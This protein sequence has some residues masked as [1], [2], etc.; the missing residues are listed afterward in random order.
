MKLDILYED[1]HIIVAYKPSGILS[2][3]DIS[4]DPDMLTLIKEYLVEKYNKPGEAYLGLVHRLDRNTS[5]VMVFAKTS[6]AASRLSEQIRNEGFNKE[7]LAI[8][9]GSLKPNNEFITLKHNLEKNEKENKSYVS[10]KGNAKEAVLMYQVLDSKNNLSLVKIKLITGRHHQIRTQFSHIGH[11]V[12]G[13]VKYGS[14]NKCGNY[15]SL[16]AYKLNIIHPTL[17]EPLEFK[18]LEQ[19]KIFDIFGSNIIE[20]YNI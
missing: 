10:N 4:K 3:E 11:P 19:D 5:G 6:K 2:Q 14:S 17:K 15:Y 16:C 12:Y 7:Y 8:V 20:E 13:D 1:N 9:E 18:K